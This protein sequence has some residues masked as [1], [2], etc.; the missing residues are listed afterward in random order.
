MALYTR[1][2]P[3]FVEDGGVQVPLTEERLADAVVD[4]AGGVEAL[5]GPQGPA[6]V[7]GADGD[8]GP[9]GPGVPVGGAAGGVLTKVSGADYD[10]GWQMPLQLGST[11]TTAL[12]GDT[13][14]EDIGGAPAA[15]SLGVVVVTTGSEPRPTGHAQVVWVAPAGV[16]PAAMAAGDILARAA[17]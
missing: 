15:A 17:A 5:R 10:T 14:A 8:Q 4:A 9:A 13:T 1:T 7:P 11:S 12:R 2:D 3:V 16:T 6:G